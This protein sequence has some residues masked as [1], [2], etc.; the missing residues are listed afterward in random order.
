MRTV[1][2]IPSP[3]TSIN[4]TDE[5]YFFKVVI[6]NAKTV[7][8]GSCGGCSDGAAIVFR[9][10]LVTQPYGVGD[11][12][13][14]TPLQRNYVLWQSGASVES[15]PNPTPTKTTTWGAVKSLYRK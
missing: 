14:D 13:I 4:G 8:T 5:Y 12:V 2:A 1:G 7:G 15:I 11:Y 6:T 9:S 3:G 10:L